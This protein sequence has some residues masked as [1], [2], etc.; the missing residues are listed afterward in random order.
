MAS[1]SSWPRHCEM[2]TPYVK[3]RSPYGAMFVFKRIAVLEV[4]RKTS[5]EYTN[6]FSPVLCRVH[7]FIDGNDTQ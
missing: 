3:I 2:T 5:E 1:Y 6:S 7:E 4:N